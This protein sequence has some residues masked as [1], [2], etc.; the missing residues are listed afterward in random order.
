ME[1]EALNKLIQKEGTVYDSVIPDFAEWV[2][3]GALD[4]SSSEVLQ[5]F[6]GMNSVERC[7]FIRDNELVARVL[8]NSTYATGPGLLRCYSLERLCDACRVDAST[9]AFLLNTLNDRDV[10]E[11]YYDIATHDSERK[12][13]EKTMFLLSGFLACGKD[14]FTLEQVMSLLQS[15]LASNTD[16]APK[17]YAIANLIEEESYRESVFQESALIELIGSCLKREGAPNA[18][19]KAVYCMWLFSRS[20]NYVEAMYDKGL[21]HALCDLFCSTKIEKIVR[22]G[23]LLLKNLFKSTRC[24]ELI[25][26]KNVSQTLTLLE[27]DKWRD[28]ELYDNIQQLRASLES[29]T[30]KISNFERYV[31]EVDTGALKWSVL[32][33]EKFWAVHFDKF[34][35][36]EFSVISKLVKLLYASEDPTTIAVACFDLGEFA[37]LYHNG[38]TICQKFRVKDRVMELIGSRDREVAREAMLCAQKLMVQKWQQVW[39]S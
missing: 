20:Q 16:A 10:F 21:V 26:D 22:V 31:L 17:L 2:A 35:D 38:K 36:D 6:E 27:Y 18:Q 37:R 12:I 25:I 32:H 33:S 29:K 3:S 15:I 34:E 19:Y 8:L 30:T 9:Y 7:D 14:R 24:L 5:R 11:I 39:T 28:I 1:P 4:E 13:I 23:L